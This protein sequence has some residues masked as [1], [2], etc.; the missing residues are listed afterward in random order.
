M[1]Q[2]TINRFNTFTTLLPNKWVYVIEDNMGQWWTGGYA[3]GASIET[4]SQQTGERGGEN[5]YS[6][7]FKA[8]S[9]DKLLTNLDAT[10]VLNNILT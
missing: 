6:F 10:W 7:N 5:K 2:T 9:A 8:I 3:V 4:Y 1:P